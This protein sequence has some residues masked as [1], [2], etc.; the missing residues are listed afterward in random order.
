MIGKKH[1]WH[2]VF[3]LLVIISSGLGITLTLVEAGGSLRPFAYFTNQSNLLV[4]IV[5]T[6]FIFN[7]K[8]YHEPFITLLYQV[9]LAIVLTAVVY[10]IMLRPFI[11]EASYSSNSITDLLVHTFT[12]LLV[13]IERYFFSVKGILQK[14]HPLY[15]LIFPLV[16]F[17]F[18]LVYA[19]LGGIYQAGTE[20]ASKYPYFFL[21]FEESG[22]GYFILVFIIVL[23][24]GYTIYYFN[25]H[26]LN[27]KEDY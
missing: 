1:T 27:K 18:T 7:H 6:Y 4:F 23:V 16:Y 19:A 12:P 2:Q 11:D 13:V 20:N 10:H 5:Y 14:S 22:Y 26:W 25:R 3:K 8:A 17:I 15:W 9:V 21:N 24:I